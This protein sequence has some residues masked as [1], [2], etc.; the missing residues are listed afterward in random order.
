VAKQK[1]KFK[2]DPIREYLFSR[3]VRQE[4]RAFTSCTVEDRP[5]VTTALWPV[6]QQLSAPNTLRFAL[7]ASRLG[8][9]SFVC[10]K[11]A[12]EAGEEIAVSR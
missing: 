10:R 12:Q 7:R 4:R 2:Q 3:K 9:P 1:R 5:T 8:F 11:E 6:V